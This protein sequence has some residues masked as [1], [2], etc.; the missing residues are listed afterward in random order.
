MAPERGA[1]VPASRPK[2]SPRRQRAV[3][4]IDR[5]GGLSRSTSPRSV[6][7]TSRRLL[8]RWSKDPSVLMLM[9][10][11]LLVSPGVI[12]V[13]KIRLNRHHREGARRSFLRSQPRRQEQY[14]DVR[15]DTG[16]NAANTPMY[17][18]QQQRERGGIADLTT[19]RSQ[20]VT[21]AGRTDENVSKRL[22]E[23]DGVWDG[24]SVV[25]VS[26]QP[27]RLRSSVPAKDM[28]ASSNFDF[29]CKEIEVRWAWVCEH[30]SPMFPTARYV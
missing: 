13:A 16:K 10:F 6:R 14:R 26:R 3:S 22:R 30:A 5:C 27:R 8:G 25:E 19:P 2:L 24:K 23:E 20:G 15:S 12:F 18:K 7:A 9:V 11:A 1:D 29:G 17:M 28:D 21:T 4:G